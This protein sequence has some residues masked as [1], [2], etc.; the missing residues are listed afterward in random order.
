MPSPPN[1]AD[2]KDMWSGGNI[3]LVTRIALVAAFVERAR[4]E[5]S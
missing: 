5:A 3:G 2:R 1:N 4:R